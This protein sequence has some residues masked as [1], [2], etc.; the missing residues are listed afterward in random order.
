MPDSTPKTLTH[1]DWN[2][3]RTYT[4]IVQHGNL[5]RASEAL[6]LTQPAVSNALRRLENQVGHKLIRRGGSIFEVTAEGRILYRESLEILARVNGISEKLEDTDTEISGTIRMVLASHVVCPFLDDIL[7]GFRSEF[8]NIILEMEVAKS[9]D[10]SERILQRSATV[11][12]CLVYQENS[13]LQYRHFFSEHFGLFCGKN[14]RLFRT[15]QITIEDL[16]NEEFVSFQTDQIAGALWPV[17]FL[18]AKHKMTGRIMCVSPNLEEVKRMI[19]IGLGIGPLPI[20]VVEPDVKRGLL[21]RL[22][23]FRDVPTVDIHLLSNPK[24]HHSRAETLFLD[25]IHS[26][27]SELPES[28]RVFPR[29]FGSS[30]L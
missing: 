30:E 25:F 1:L 14:H 16:R 12:I 27:L 29:D 18:R 17:A 28:D 2:L 11:G 9:E 19:V 5:S 7:V 15:S 6:F 26:R 8:P 23:P 10:I 4:V 13:K 21:R 22:P 3:L 24:S 20:H